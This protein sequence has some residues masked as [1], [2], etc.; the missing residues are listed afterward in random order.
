MNPNFDEKDSLKALV[1]AS[2]KIKDQNVLTNKKIHDRVSEAAE[3]DISERYFTCDQRHLSI[4]PTTQVENLSVSSSL[5]GP[6]ALSNLP[7][8]PHSVA[9]PVNNRSLNL[10][11]FANTI[12][13]LR[14]PKFT[15]RQ[16]LV[17]GYLH[18]T[19][20]SM[21]ENETLI[22]KLGDSIFET[23]LKEAAQPIV[24]LG[25]ALAATMKAS[26]DRIEAHSDE[27]RARPLSS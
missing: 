8:M 3:F 2:G 15:F 25:G 12:D 21:R 6:P 10:T 4:N 20:I 7:P 27:I 9:F 11:E 1:D 5:P 26:V 19:H 22:A 14:F 16:G 18:H 13:G 23:N 17:I 24:E